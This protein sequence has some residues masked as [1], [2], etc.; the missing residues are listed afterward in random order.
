M[1]YDLLKNDLELHGIIKDIETWATIL[2]E[3]HK[4]V[5]NDVLKLINQIEKELEIY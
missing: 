5:K 2:G 1:N 4:G 3:T